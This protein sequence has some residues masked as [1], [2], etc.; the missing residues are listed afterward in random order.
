M[1]QP[2]NGKVCAVI[3]LRPGV[4]QEWLRAILTDSG[5]VVVTGSAGDGLSA[6]GMVCDKQPVLLVVDSN[7]LDDEALSLMC[8][9]PKSVDLI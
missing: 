8:Y 9:N 5:Q 3:A 6:L 1:K 2:D 4:M 7:L